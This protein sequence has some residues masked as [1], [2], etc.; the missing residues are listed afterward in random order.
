MDFESWLDKTRQ[1]IAK[2][3]PAFFEQVTARDAISNMP[4]PTEDGC[5]DNANPV[6]KYQKY[7]YHGAKR[8]HN[9]NKPT[10]HQLQ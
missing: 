4:K 10:I 9:H 3:E 6:T 2:E 5:V 7:L 1:Q 8:L